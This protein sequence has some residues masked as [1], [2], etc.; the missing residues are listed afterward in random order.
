MRCF[1]VLARWSSVGVVIA[2][3]IGPVS[4]ATGKATVTRTNTEAT[5]ENDSLGIVVSSQ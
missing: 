4:G 2:G 5:L 1:H 3:M